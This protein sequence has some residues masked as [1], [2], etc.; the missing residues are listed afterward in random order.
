MTNEE[1]RE[2]IEAVKA[3]HALSLRDCIEWRRL[4]K[5]IAAVEQATSAE[6][7]HG[8]NWMLE[9]VIGSLET[10]PDGGGDVR[11]MT[12]VKSIEDRAFNE[13]VEASAAEWVHCVQDKVDDEAATVLIRIR[14][15]KRPVAERTKG[16]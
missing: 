11:V 5:A 8:A 4:A 9:S 6:D 7:H 3:V 14:A 10:Y 16:G 15:L 2:L 13:G 1:L 12:A